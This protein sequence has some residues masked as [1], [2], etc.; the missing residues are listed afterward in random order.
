MTPPYKITWFRNERPLGTT[1]WDKSF[2]KAKEH[3]VAFIPIH[4]ATRV[5]IR[6]DNDGLV[7]SH[8]RTVS[9]AP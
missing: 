9:K 5:E 2:A 3:A 1:P 7:F 8:P 6:D 4:K